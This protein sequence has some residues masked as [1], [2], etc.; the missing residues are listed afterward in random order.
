MKIIFVIQRMPWL[1]D[2]KTQFSLG[3]LYLSTILKQIE[4]S[5]INIYDANANKIENIPYADI[6]GFSA[7]YNTYF[8][9]VNLAY[10]IKKKFKGSKIIIGG[11]H[12]TLS[13]K[14]IDKIFDSVFVGE[15]L[16]SIKNYIK[17]FKNNS[18]QRYYHQTKLDDI[19]DIYPDRDLI[20]DDFLRTKSVFTQSKEYKQ[21]GA[22]SIMF[23]RGCPYKC[24]FCASSAIYKQKIR[25]RK[26]ESIKKEI[27]DITT[28]YGIY[29]FRVQD[30]TFTINKN[31]FRDLC[32]IL[33]P[34]EIFYRCSTRVNHID[35]EMAELLYASG[36]REIGIGVEMADD[37]ILKIF[38]KQ[39]TV[40]QMEKAIKFIQKYP[41]VIRAF[42]MLGTPYDSPETLQKNID[43]I[44]RNGITGSTVAKFL[45][46][47]GTHIYNNMNTY[48]IKSIK[49]DTCMN[50][51][52]TTPFV[53]NIIRTDISEEEHI[54]IVQPFYDY[55]YRKNF[56]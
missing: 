23:S 13:H 29:Q 15:A 34:F 41:I 22:T 37:D 48:K 25:F 44:E 38:N 14:T 1:Y 28:K 19:D 4:C 53:P 43:F 21:G 31:Y 11:S 42:F 55:L 50:V 17:D 32:K 6:Y 39:V 8:D 36:C 16:N 49:L 27:K 52:K 24:S 47:P 51:S 9:S 40:A 26:L 30:D 2:Y 3:I 5:D 20:P 18:T 45:P 10:E 56:I 46:L 7:T 12:P 35:E 33:T 54:K